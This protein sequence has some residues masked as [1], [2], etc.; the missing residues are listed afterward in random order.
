[1]TVITAN[2]YLLFNWSTSGGNFRNNVRGE[3][4]FGK[5]PDTRFWSVATQAKLANYVDS[6]MRLYYERYVRINEHN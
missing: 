5:C 6:K 1:M 2:M 4:F 3:I